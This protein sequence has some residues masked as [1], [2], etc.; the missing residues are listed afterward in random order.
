M[1]YFNTTGTALYALCIRCALSVM[2]VMGNYCIHLYLND[3]LTK[4]I[5]ISSELIVLSFS[6]GIS[7]QQRHKIHY[8]SS[9]CVYSTKINKIKQLTYK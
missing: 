1:L 4:I 3:S 8:C 2:F 5:I 9:K 7:H 6:K